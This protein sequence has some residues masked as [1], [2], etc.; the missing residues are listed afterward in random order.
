M[1]SGAKFHGQIST[2]ALRPTPLWPAGRSM[3]EKP[4]SWL[5]VRCADRISPP[6]TRREISRS[7]GGAHPA[8]A[9]VVIA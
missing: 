7:A 4:S 5:F 2:A 1:A 9:T 3:L 6:H 8:A